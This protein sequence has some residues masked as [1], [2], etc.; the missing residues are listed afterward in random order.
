MAK[1]VEYRG[2]VIANPEAACPTGSAL[3]LIMASP[4]LASAL[5]MS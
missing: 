1:S 3:S 4:G 2:F 5:W